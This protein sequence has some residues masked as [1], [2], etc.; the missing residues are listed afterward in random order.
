MDARTLTLP[1]D[2]H[3]EHQLTRV[4]LLRAGVPQRVIDD[5]L[6]ITKKRPNRPGPTA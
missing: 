1:Y 6:P 4:S 2:D 5:E 3:A